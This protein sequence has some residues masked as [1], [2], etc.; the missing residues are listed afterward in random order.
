MIFML[1]YVYFQIFN[2]N[3]LQWDTCFSFL[4]C[5]WRYV[6]YSFS[7]PKLF[8]SKICYRSNLWVCSIK[9]I[10]LKKI[11]IFTGKH[12]CWSLL[13]MRLHAFRPATLF[14]KTPTHVFSCKY[15]EIFKSTYF[16]EPLRTTAYVILDVRFTL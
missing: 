12:M 15:Y 11:D 2:V 14:K 5:L 7:E 4:F 13:L 6:L 9:E 8:S 10:V 3:N 16:E 1:P